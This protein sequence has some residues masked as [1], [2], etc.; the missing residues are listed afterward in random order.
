MYTVHVEIN[1]VFSPGNLTA[2]NFQTADH[3]TQAGKGEVFLPTLWNRGQLHVE[4]K[5]HS[6]TTQGTR[7]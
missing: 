3:R 2:I 5:D 6:P 4:L 7:F 1:L